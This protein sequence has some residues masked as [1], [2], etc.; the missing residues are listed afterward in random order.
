MRPLTGTPEALD[1]F[2]RARLGWPAEV[3]ATPA[4]SLFENLDPAAPPVDSIRVLDA[5]GAPAGDLVDITWSQGLV[6]GRM[7]PAESPSSMPFE[8]LRPRPQ[9]LEGL[10]ELVHVRDGEPQLSPPPAG[11]RTGVL[12]T[13]SLRTAEGAVSRAAVR[14]LRSTL[15]EAGDQSLPVWHLPMADHVVE[16]TLGQIGLDVRPAPAAQRSSPQGAVILFSG[17]SGS[18]K[19]TLARRL[20]DRLIEETQRS[21]VLLDGDVVRRHLS[22]GLGFSPA[23]REVNVKRI[24]WVAAQIAGEGAIAICSPIAPFESSRRAIEE[25]A[26]EEDASF[27][28]IHVATPLEECERRD[29]KGLYARARAGEIPDFTGVSSPYEVPEAPTLRID[30]TGISVDE[31]LD[32][33]V[34]SLAPLNLFEG[35]QA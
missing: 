21:V 14:I 25:M 35:V 9:D 2:D 12:V 30:T 11:A 16:P 6:S 32:R 33:V 29:R 28:L 13:R 22:A 10:T 18:G 1:A 26:H 31:A 34:A 4:A 19:S 23:D 3:A 8:H 15:E 17:L 7:V 5:E 24:G 20:R 27:A